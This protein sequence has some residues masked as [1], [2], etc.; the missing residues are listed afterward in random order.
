MIQNFSQGNGSENVWDSAAL[1]WAVLFLFSL[2]Q[3]PRGHIQSDHCWWSLPAWAALI[4]QS[5]IEVCCEGRNR[6]AGPA[7]RHCSAHLSFPSPPSLH[8][9]SFGPEAPVQFQ[10]FHIEP[11]IWLIS[12]RLL[13]SSIYINLYLSLTIAQ[14]SLFIYLPVDSF[15][16]LSLDSHRA[17]DRTW[18]C[19]VLWMPTSLVECMSILTQWK[20]PFVNKHC[21]QRANTCWYFQY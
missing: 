14:F 2:F 15:Y 16:N 8:P 3:E 10:H 1:T 13:S 9:E 11:A 7:N 5:C 19:G 18:Y 21:D 17:R 20:G 12:P 4:W 6:T